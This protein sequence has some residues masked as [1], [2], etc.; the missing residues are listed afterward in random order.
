MKNPLEFFRSL[1]TAA[2]ADK[3]WRERIKADHEDR[4]AFA[5]ELTCADRIEVF[6]LDH[7]IGR[8]PSHALQECDAAFP[9][10]PYGRSTKILK[11]AAV[12]AQDIPKWSAAIAKILQSEEDNSQARCHHPIHGIRIYAGDSVLFETSLCWQCN[13]YYFPYTDHFSWQ[14]LT[15]DANTL[16]TLLKKFM[17]IPK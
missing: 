1:H 11:T 16:E 12:S 3:Q 15:T 10:R 9:I 7:S 5:K 2:A 17:P 14:S 13:N 6:L 4:V 8:V